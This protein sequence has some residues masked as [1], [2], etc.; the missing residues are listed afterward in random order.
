MKIS[1][2]CHPNMPF[3]PWLPIP[4]YTQPY[5]ALPELPHNPRTR[6]TIPPILWRRKQT[7]RDNETSW[8]LGGRAKRYR[9]TIRSQSSQRAFEYFSPLDPSRKRLP[10]IGV[11][12]PARDCPEARPAAM[13]LSRNLLHLFKQNL[14]MAEQRRRCH[15]WVPTASGGHQNCLPQQPAESI[16]RAS[17]TLWELLLQRKDPSATVL[18]LRVPWLMATLIGRSSLSATCHSSCF[19]CP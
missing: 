19:C 8:Q 11:R 5:R 18:T 13:C 15:F 6:S 3:L 1:E 4:F 12:V 7:Q 2:D 17:T 14:P 10:G 9:P 16:S